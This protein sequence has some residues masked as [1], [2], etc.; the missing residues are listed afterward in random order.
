MT[1]KKPPETPKRK[2]RS[3]V[4]ASAATQRPTY[5][6]LRQQLAD[7]LKREKA[8]R[9]DLQDSDQ[10]LAESA[11]ELQDCKRQLTEASEHQTATSEVLG[12]ISRCL[13]MS[14]RCSMPLSR[15][16]RKFVVLMTW[17]C[18][19]VRGTLWFRGVI[20]VPYPFA[21]AAGPRSL[22]T[23]RNVSGCANTVRFIFP[24][25]GSKTTS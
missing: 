8:G 9:K 12:I 15:V 25:A 16:L 19:S 10:Q 6:E 18:D 24:I 11:K 7:S 14:S 1:A 20:L 4:K 22:L 23:H 2:Q 13:R 3:P 17:C 5:A 21:L